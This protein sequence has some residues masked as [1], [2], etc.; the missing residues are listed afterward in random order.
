MRDDELLPRHIAGDLYGPVDGWFLFYRPNQIA[1]LL[2]FRQRQDG[3]LIVV[4]THLRSE[5]GL[6]SGV[7]RGISVGR[8]EATA[9]TTDAKE[10]IVEACQD[11]WIVEGLKPPAS[12][13]VPTWVYRRL[14]ELDARSEAPT[15]PRLKLRIPPRPGKRADEFYRRVAEAYGWLATRSRRPAAELAE[16]N[17]VPITTVHRWIKE[18]RHRGFLGPGRRGGAG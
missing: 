4:E 17:D 1:A 10:K 7:L 9:N 18:A 11:E 6:T 16:L 8:A 3:R 12:R 13:Q 2:R 5:D 15:R 14:T